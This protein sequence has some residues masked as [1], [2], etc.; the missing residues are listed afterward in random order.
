MQNTSKIIILWLLRICLIVAPAYNLMVFAK[1]EG[2]S[3]TFDW[4]TQN[5]G[6]IAWA[7]GSYMILLFTTIA[8]NINW[9]QLGA[10]VLGASGLAYF[11]L[12]PEVYTSFLDIPFFQEHKKALPVIPYAYTVI[13]LLLATLLKTRYGKKK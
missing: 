13:V 8:F 11:Y 12:T 1:G 7:L 4:W 9:A 6:F 10:L 5:A 2:A 3:N